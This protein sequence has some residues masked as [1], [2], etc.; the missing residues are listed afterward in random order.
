MKIIFINPLL[1]SNST[2]HV[3]DS[4]V[5]FIRR[6]LRVGPLAEAV[7]VVEKIFSVRNLLMFQNKFIYKIKNKLL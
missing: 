1:Y 5:L 6:A 4:I 3:V 2:I 7:V